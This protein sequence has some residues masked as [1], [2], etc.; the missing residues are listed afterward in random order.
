MDIPE[1][2]LRLLRIPDS[3]KVLSVVSPE[4]FPHSIVLGTIVVDDGFLYA[5]E[6]FMHHTVA[7]LEQCP[8]A[9]FLVWK[10]RVGYSIRAVAEARITEG[11]VF[12]KVRSELSRMGMEAVAAWRFR[13]VEA[14]DESATPSSGEKVL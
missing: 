1:P 14:V 3:S 2:L 5:G 7:Y 12:E 11:P 8:H 6:A 4:G 9:E 10:G 13:P